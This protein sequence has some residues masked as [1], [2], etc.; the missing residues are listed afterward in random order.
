MSDSTR[1]RPNDRTRAPNLALG[2]KAF[3][4]WS[5]YRFE[6]MELQKILTDASGNHVLIDRHIQ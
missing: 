2:Q 1:A 5:V 4:R 6:R 3:L